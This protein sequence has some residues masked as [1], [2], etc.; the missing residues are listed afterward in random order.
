MSR[1]HRAIPSHK[2]QVSRPLRSPRDFT[3]KESG[4]ADFQIKTNRHNRNTRQIGQVL[5][6]INSTSG[7]IDRSDRTNA[8]PKI[9]LNQNINMT[10]SMQGLKQYTHGLNEVFI[11]KKPPTKNYQQI[12][13]KN[14]RNYSNTQHNSHQD[15]IMNNSRNEIPM[16]IQNYQNKIN[17]LTG[18]SFHGN[19]SFNMN[20]SRVGDNQEQVGTIP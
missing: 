13:L 19:T 8:S 6:T 9:N 12:P 7:I 3:I 14:N 20:M 15:Q 5:P 4:S 10:I 18:R 2:L 1:Q 17:A 11:K 16:H